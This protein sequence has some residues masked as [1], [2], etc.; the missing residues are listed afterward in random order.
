MEAVKLKESWVD[1]LNRKRRPRT[2]ERYEGVVSLWEK[3][4]LSSGINFLEPSLVELEDFCHRSR[5]RHGGEVYVPSSST[6]KNDMVALRGFYKWAFDRKYVC[7]NETVLLEAPKVDNAKPKP[8]DDR[9]VWRY[10]R[11]DCWSLEHRVALGFA[12][13]NGLRSAEIGGLR[14]SDINFRGKRN[15]DLNKN[16]GELDISRKGGKKQTLPWLML[17]YRFVEH[18]KTLKFP[19]PMEASVFYARWLLDVKALIVRAEVREFLF[20]WKSGAVAHVMNK[21]H[22][23]NMANGNLGEEMAGIHL[24]RFRHTFGTNMARAGFPAEAIR[25]WMGHTDLATTMRYMDTRKL[26][27]EWLEVGPVPRVVNSDADMINNIINEKEKDGN[28]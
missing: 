22:S 24:H 11:N 5:S 4:C 9:V 7:E 28:D 6:V 25:E 16:F 8:I 10:L 15:F 27:D 23:R 14:V 21:M 1:Y 17:A 2:V 12:L 26:A 3:Y 19:V 13:F 20:P 18:Q